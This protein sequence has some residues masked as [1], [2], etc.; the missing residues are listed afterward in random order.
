MAWVIWDPHIGTFTQCLRLAGSPDADA[1][2][3]LAGCNTPLHLRAPQA[4]GFRS[5]FP[6]PAP[7]AA[8]SL[9]LPS[10]TFNPLP[11]PFP[12]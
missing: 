7:G 10:L 5:E 9:T 1:Q 4:T 8:P 6:G 3:R 2:Y 12:L 11:H